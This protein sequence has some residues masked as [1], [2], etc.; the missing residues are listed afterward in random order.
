[1]T[2]SKLFARQ[3]A[4]REVWLAGYNTGRADGE[5]GVYERPGPERSDVWADG[6]EVG[7]AD[8]FYE[9]HRCTNGT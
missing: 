1:M 8:A 4:L 5:L 7:Q 6:Y 2:Q 9:A 3:Q